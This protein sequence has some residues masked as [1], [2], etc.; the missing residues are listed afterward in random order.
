MAEKIILPV[1]T[2]NFV[3]SIDSLQMKLQFAFEFGWW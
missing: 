1:S 3:N 2:V